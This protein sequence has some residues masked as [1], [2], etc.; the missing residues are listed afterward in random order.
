MV[1]SPERRDHVQSLERGLTVILAF[2][3]HRPRLSL[4]EIAEH[5]GLTRPTVRRIL[6][7]LQDL[8]YIRAVGREFA[9]TPHVLALGYAYLS[10]LNL[11]E[12]AQPFM[13]ELTATT[14][15]TCSLA[16]LDGEDAVYLSRVP[17]RRVM[18]ITLTT[19][20]RL[21]AYATSM[22]RVLLAGL[23]R[24]DV[25]T[26][27]ATAKLVPI[28]PHT[29]TDVDELRARI[30]QVREQGWA[31]VDQEL[32]EGVRSFSAPVRD[33]TGSVI[34]ALAMSCSPSVVSLEQ[35]HQ[36]ILPAVLRSASCISEQLGAPPGSQGGAGRDN[37]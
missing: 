7:T 9:L 17:A 23:P 30:D 32:E 33:A 26:F 6:I 24:R 19:G 35:I 18:S 12:V 25:D 37:G 28:T 21:P 14:G 15:H 34:A 16:A 29:L 2:S 13:E 8:G 11:T 36:D 10:S 1:K 5:T 27:L 22:G 3:R 4:A 20:T 31:L